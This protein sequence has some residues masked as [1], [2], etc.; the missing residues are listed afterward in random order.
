MHSRP[1]QD[2]L[3]SLDTYGQQL[4]CI[5]CFNVAITVSITATNVVGLT[6]VDTITASYS[7]APAVVSALSFAG[8]KIP[9]GGKLWYSDVTTA[10]FNATISSAAAPWMGAANVVLGISVGAYPLSAGNLED[11]HDVSALLYDPNSL[12][13]SVFPGIPPSTAFSATKLQ[14]RGAAFHG[15]SYRFQLAVTSAAGLSSGASSFVYLDITPPIVG[16]AYFMSLVMND[17]AQQAQ[18]ALSGLFD[19]E[20]GIKEIWWRVGGDSA[21]VQARDFGKASSWV[22]LTNLAMSTMIRNLPSSAQTISVDLSNARMANWTT[23][24]FT[25]AVINHSWTTSG[26][27]LSVAYTDLTPLALNS[28][29]ASITITAID[30]AGPSQNQNITGEQTVE[31]HWLASNVVAGIAFVTA[32]LS[33]PTRTIV[34]SP[35][36]PDSAVQSI[37]IPFGG[38]VPANV[39]MT[40]CVNATSNS[41]PPVV[42]SDCQLFVQP[43]TLLF[44]AS[45]VQTGLVYRLQS[46]ASAVATIFSNWTDCLLPEVQTITYWLVSDTDFMPVASGSVAVSDLGVPISI[47]ASW[48]FDSYKF[49]FM[50]VMGSSSSSQNFCTA[51]QAVDLTPPVPLGQIYDA[52]SGGGL[53]PNALAVRYS[54]NT[55][56]YLVRWDDWIDPDSGVKLFSLSLMLDGDVPRVI[57]QVPLT[58]DKRAFLFDNLALNVSSKYFA[59]LSATNNALLS[60]PNVRSPG[61]EIVAVGVSEVPVISIANGIDVLKN[62]VAAYLFI[63]GASAYIGLSWSGFIADS[64]LVPNYRVDLVSNSTS[65]A[66]PISSPTTQNDIQLQVPSRDDI[67]ILSVTLQNPDGTSQ[68]AVADRAIWV[69]KLQVVPPSK[70]SCDVDFTQLSPGNHTVPFTATLVPAVDSQGLLVSQTLGFRHAEMVSESSS[71]LQLSSNDTSKS[72]R[73]VYIWGAPS[74]QEDY[75]IECVWQG[76][77]LAGQIT[78]MSYS[79]TRVGSSSALPTVIAL[80]SWTKVAEP[81]SGTDLAFFDEVTITPNSSFMVGMQSFSPTVQNG[82]QVASLSY[83]VYYIGDPSVASTT[84]AAADTSTQSNSTTSS[85]ILTST[86]TPTSIAAGSTPTAVVSSLSNAS[87]SSSNTTAVNSTAGISNSTSGTQDVVTTSDAVYIVPWTTVDVLASQRLAV[88]KINVGS[89]LVSIA[90]FDPDQFLANGGF[91][92]DLSTVYVCVTST[93]FATSFSQSACSNG[94]TWDSIPPTP[95]I[96]AINDARSTADILYLTATDT[97]SVSWEGFV[98]ANWH[99]TNDSGIL[100]YQWAVGSFAGADDYVAFSSVPGMELDATAAVLLTDGSS[101]YATVAATDYAGRTAK[102]SSSLVLVDS[103]PPVL[104]SALSVL[105][106]ANP[107]GTTFVRIDFLPWQDPESGLSSVV[108]TVESAYGAADVLPIWPVTFS[109]VA[110]ANLPLLPGV[111]YLARMVATNRASLSQEVVYSITAGSAVEM[112]YLVDGTDPQ[113]SKLFDGNPQSY[114]VSWNFTGSI[115]AFVIGVGTSPRQDD[116]W[117]F[118]QVDASLQSLTVPLSVSDGVKIFTTV[119]VQDSGG[120]FQSFVTA[121]MICDTSP[122]I[123][124]WVNVGPGMVHQMVV[125]NQES[126]SASWIGFS[127]AESDIATYEY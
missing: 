96:V 80:S 105:A 118:R 24:Y 81:S 35:Y 88:Y 113:H 107:D 106:R 87:D 43:P 121:G 28:F 108:W 124:G 25:V 9:Y 114:T 82:V 91:P 76:R 22:N 126:I 31:V 83:C 117:S 48:I 46:D 3:S 55:A 17:A 64:L 16:P 14:F 1:A 127:D 32:Q 75:P 63:P 53:D 18:V 110:Y 59:T 77:D 123:R 62:G 47:D 8:S 11:L 79:G 60:S 94:I 33:D 58:G 70:V 89:S 78:V 100:S 67:Y 27:S 7:G 119:F 51:Q 34:T 40:V 93:R 125:P 116:I 92:S 99:F 56:S 4:N 45:C 74:I 112:V 65:T 85:S 5:N 15:E 72:G 98:K 102:A 21:S 50:A 71:T 41:I 13:A 61:V 104:T 86:D 84:T 37:D 66:V 42:H 109:N 26:D 52:Y 120:N 30:V 38:P 68:K 54:T 73:V 19:P 2:A 49:C 69:S 29:N 90:V 122:P 10:L 20:S 95:G 44:D 12:Q 103:T 97:I 39:Q 57:S 111:T 115:H 23:L 6:A 36:Y 101:I